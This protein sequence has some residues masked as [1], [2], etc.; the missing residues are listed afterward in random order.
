MKET[1]QV[2]EKHSMETPYL[3][4]QPVFRDNRG[5]FAPIKLNGTWVQSNISVNSSI[6][7]FRGMHIQSAP[8]QQDKLVSVIQGRIV[9]IV[10]DLRKDSETYK[11][12]DSFILEEGD[13]IC[14]PKG[15]AHGF[16]TL[17][18]NTIV[19]YLVDEEYSPENEIGILWSSI[20]DVKSTIDRFCFN[21]IDN[22]I[23]FSDKD[24][25][26]IN[27]NELL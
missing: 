16:L 23:V 20:P 25:Q 5:L 26:G 17:S 21:N 22:D 11:K 1:Q 15:Y 10:I 2:M 6:Y 8:K 3:L 9:D 7:T 13:S 18:P 27:I 14:V 24:K 19:N 12:V 4:K